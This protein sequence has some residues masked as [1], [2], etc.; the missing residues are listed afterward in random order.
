ML[1]RLSRRLITRICFCGLISLLGLL[2][3]EAAFSA[4]RPKQRPR[5]KT[6]QK[7]YLEHTDHMRFD[8][9]QHPAKFF[10]GNVVFLHNGTYFYCDSAEVYDEIN[11]FKAFGHVKMKQGDTLTLTSDYLYYDG[12]TQQTYARHNVK[13][14]HRKSVLETDSLDY[15]RLY[16]V[17]YYYDGGR[18]TDAGN[19]LTSDYGEYLPDTR[20]AVFHYNV[21]LTGKNIEVKTDTLYYNTITKVAHVRNHSNIFT[22]KSEIYTTDAVYHTATGYTEMRERSTI[23]NAANT[24]VGDHIINVKERGETFAKGNV[25]IVD[26]S[27]KTV[28]LGHDVYYNEKLG[29]AVITDSALVKDYSNPQD[30]LFLHADTLKLFSYYLDTDTAYRVLH[31]Y[32]NVRTFRS[33]VQAVADSLNFNNRTKI[34]ALYYDPIVWQ[35]RQQIVGEEIYLH[36]NDSVVDSARVVHQAMLVEALDSISY[37]QVSSERF[38]AYFT[39]GQMKEAL[40][41]GNVLAINYQL[42]RDSIAVGM[43]RLETSLMRLYVIDRKLQKIWTPEA[44]GQFY[45]IFLVNASN[46]YLPG[47]S[48]FDYIRPRDKY[49]LME[50]RSKN[51]GTEIK[52]RPR[53]QAPRQSLVSTPSSTSANTLSSSL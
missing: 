53:R 45:P 51:K 43:N 4:R 10:V 1:V 17:G 29:A 6:D 21:R 11:S 44:M 19:I 18:L 48:W 9:M 14:R 50:R 49:D 46:R 28:L 8:Q 42:N 37:Q 36:M 22:G 24:I 23:R 7:I 27:N 16:N 39:D 41:E 52:P 34:M 47:F 15:D 3:S 40:A 13:L 5:K 35:E 32:R 12:T 20:E 31:G 30:T 25:E 38:T 2:C 26:Q 33:D